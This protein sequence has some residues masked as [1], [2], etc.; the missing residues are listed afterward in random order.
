MHIVHYHLKCTF[1]NTFLESH[2]YTPTSVAQTKSKQGLVIFG[3]IYTL[4][5]ISVH[6]LP[7]VTTTGKQHSDPDEDVD[8]VQVNTN[9]SEI[10]SI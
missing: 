5:Y 9:R 3:L 7:S 1:K 10:N 6:L 8:G 2:Y 4:I